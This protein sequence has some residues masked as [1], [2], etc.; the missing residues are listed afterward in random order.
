MVTGLENPSP[1][2]QHDEPDPPVSE[3]EMAAALKAFR[4]RLK[5]ARLADES[6]LGGRYTSSG[7]HSDI[8]AIIPPGQFGA[9][10]WRALEKA[11]KLKHTGQGFYA[12][13]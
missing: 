4:K 7:R 3:A 10:V 9:H 6:R 8:D 13:R 2:H 5:L 1:T 12:E 11:G